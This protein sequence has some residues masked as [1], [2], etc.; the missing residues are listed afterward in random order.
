MSEQFLSL[1]EHN[2]FVRRMDDENNRQNKRLSNL[3]SA[4]NQLS[5]LVASVKVL[6]VN[7]ENIAKEINEQGIRLKEIEG[8]PVKRY[9]T[10]IGCVITGL[11]GAAI[12][13]FLTH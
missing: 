11:V 1:Q 9:E 12:S 2:E 8:K 5:E 6:A 3:E 4:I 10:I 7:V 13:Y